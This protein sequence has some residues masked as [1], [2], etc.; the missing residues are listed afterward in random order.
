MVSAIE[1]D[2]GKTESLYME[3]TISDRVDKESLIRRRHVSECF[4]KMEEWRVWSK[5]KT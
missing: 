3:D 2:K 1:K 4:Y 5:M